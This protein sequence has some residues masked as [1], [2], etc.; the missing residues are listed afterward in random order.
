M[1]KLLL[2]CII[3]FPYIAYSQMLSVDE[4]MNL[5]KR[6]PSGISEYLVPKSWTLFKT[7]NSYSDDK[8]LLYQESVTWGQRIEEYTDK[9][10]AWV[11]YSKKINIG[12]SDFQLGRDKMGYKITLK[13]NFFSSAY[14]SKIKEQIKI[15]KLKLLQDEVIDDGIIQSY[16]FGG[17]YIAL[18]TGPGS[19]AVFITKK[20]VIKD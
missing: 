5:A 18:F 12:D 4:L 6:K 17:Y 13:Y 10:E 16:D 11:T 3:L 1:A 19:Y 9:A 8:S 7:D 20:E 2:I 15:K 14:Y